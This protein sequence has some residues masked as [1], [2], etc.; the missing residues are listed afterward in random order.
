[1]DLGETKWR[2]DRRDSLG[3]VRMVRL[4]SLSL[5]YKDKVAPVVH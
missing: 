5:I 2:D 3:V 4:S 1:V